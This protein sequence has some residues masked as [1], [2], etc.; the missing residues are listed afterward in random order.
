M[1]FPSCIA[2]QE[3]YNIKSEGSFCS[4]LEKLTLMKLQIEII[5]NKDLNKMCEYAIKSYTENFDHRIQQL[6]ITFP[7]DC[8][9]ELG[10]NFWVGARK[11]PHPIHFDPNIDLCLN[12]VTKFVYILSHA[13]G[14]KFSKDEH[15]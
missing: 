5:I 10:L 6:L 4:Q 13:L 15:P 12:Y 11:L 9:T 8:K 1:Y 2:Q 14:I 3:S 7:P